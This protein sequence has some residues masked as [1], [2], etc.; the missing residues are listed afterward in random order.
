MKPDNSDTFFSAR[1]PE[2]KVLSL[3]FNR[4][5]SKNVEHPWRYFVAGGLSLAKLQQVL[6]E[7]N[8]VD[9]DKNALAKSVG[10]DSYSNG[11]IFTNAE[12]EPVNPAVRLCLK[13]N[14]IFT[15]DISTPG[16]FYPDVDAGGAEIKRRMRAI[17]SLP[18]AEIQAARDALAKEVDAESFDGNFFHF[19]DWAS[20]VATASPPR[21]QMFRLKSN[22]AFVRGEYGEGF[23]PDWNTDEGFTIGEKLSEIGKHIYP[24]KRFSDWL[25]SFALDISLTGRRE[26]ERKQAEVENIGGEWIIKVPVVVEGIFGADGKGGVISGYKEGWVLPPGAA[27][28]SVSDYFAKLENSGSLRSLPQAP[29]P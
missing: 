5:F 26:R 23:S 28:I 21:E 2:S 11:F 7:S 27:P 24:E 6:A 19:T 4:P 10:A 8:D 3:Q 20:D 16:N 13:S 22:P 15:C 12:V 29:K 17:E 18:E 25:E 14:S 1:K 9:A